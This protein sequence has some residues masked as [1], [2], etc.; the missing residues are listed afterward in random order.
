FAVSL[1]YAC[2]YEDRRHVDAFKVSRAFLVFQAGM[3]VLG[4]L[5]GRALKAWIAP[6]APWLA[7]RWSSGLPGQQND[8][9]CLEGRGNDG[10]PPI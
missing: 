7:R 8:H 5:G 4:W 3:P 1:A 2:P 6:I 10:S 9:R